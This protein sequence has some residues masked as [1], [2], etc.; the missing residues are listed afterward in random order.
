MENLFITATR[1]KYRFN[2]KGLISVEDLWDLSL[3]ALDA[4]Y[5]AL[6]EEQSKSNG[7]SLMSTS[8]SKDKELEN[9]LAIVTHIFG[10][11]MQEIEDHK[12]AQARREQKQKLME[13]IDEKKNEDLRSKST[14][15]LTKMLEDLG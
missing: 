3:T 2:Y 15:E 4:I 6:Y 9:K 7:V 1:K 5:R 10:V 12:A 11:K 8:S 14:E 13:L